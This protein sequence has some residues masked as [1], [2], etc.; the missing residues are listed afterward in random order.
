MSGPL[1]LALES[2]CDETGL[3]IVEGGRRIRANVVASQVALHAATGGIVPEP[4][5]AG[6]CR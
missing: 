4:T 3:A 1:V 2:S 5:C 6:S